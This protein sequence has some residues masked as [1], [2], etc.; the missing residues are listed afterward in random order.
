[1]TKQ[2]ASKFYMIPEEVLDEYAAWGLCG[3]VKKVMADWKYDDQDLERLSMIMALHDMGFAN[4]DVEIYMRLLL[5]GDST[6]PERMRMLNRQRN[7]AL[8]EIHLRERQLER[9]DYLRHEIRQNK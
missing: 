8:D 4:A 9:M 5:K 7:K 2:E 3:E 6:K 1:M